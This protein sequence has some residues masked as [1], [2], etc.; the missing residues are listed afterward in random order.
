MRM[1]RHRPSHPATGDASLLAWVRQ[2]LRV[3]ATRPDSQLV[4]IWF[5]LAQ[6]ALHHWGLVGRAMIGLPYALCSSLIVGCE[7]PAMA[8]VGPR[9]RLYHPH[10]IVLSPHA[11]LGADCQLRHAVTVGNRTDRDGRD[12]GVASLGDGV[13]LGAGC[14]IIG[15]VHVG[16]HAR[17][18]ALALVTKSVPAGAVVAG[19]P[20]RVLRVEGSDDIAAGSAHPPRRSAA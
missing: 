4:L 18:G 12:L 14:A 8:R 11:T 9:L 20:A 16:N 6:W 2:D 5:R 15:D 19:N 13:D 3:N 10:G 17:V 1:P 7:L